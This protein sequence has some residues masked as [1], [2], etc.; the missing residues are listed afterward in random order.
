MILARALC[1]LAPVSGAVLP[2]VA[3]TAYGMG[4]SITA[5]APAQWAG[6]LYGEDHY[7]SGVRT[8]TVA[9]TGG[10]FVFGPLPGV[11]ADW[12]G[13]YVPSYIL[14]TLFLL[15]SFLIVQGLYRQRA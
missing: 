1:C 2:F 11:L 3:I 4:M 12:L 8:I 5:V 6:D 14:F 15:T 10:I 9:Y 13:G 7:E